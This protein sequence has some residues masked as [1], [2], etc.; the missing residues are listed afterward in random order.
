MMN[1]LLGRIHF[2]GSLLFINGIF[3]PMFL[4]G[5]AGMHRRWY[6]GG[7]AYPQ[8]TAGVIHWNS[9]MSYSAFWLG[10]FQLFFIVNFFWSMFAGKKTGRNPWHGTTLEW[11]APSPPPH[12][13]FD[14]PLMVYRG[15]YEYSVPGADKDYSPQT[16]PPPV[17]PASPTP[18]LPP[19]V[20]PNHPTSSKD[21]AH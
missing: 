20:D 21:P 1:D 13:N 2:W 16:E 3:F 14:K 19:A 4:Q 11:D 17:S 18:T 15:P 5:M 6:D 10:V 8:L 7:L 9:F 12:G